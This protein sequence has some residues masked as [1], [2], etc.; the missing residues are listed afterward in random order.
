[1]DLSACSQNG[2]IAKARNNGHSPVKDFW[3]T[4]APP[5]NPVSDSKSSLGINGVRK[6]SSSIGNQL[7]LFFSWF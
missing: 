3:R 2:N 5:V 6:A 4:I 1:M 7:G